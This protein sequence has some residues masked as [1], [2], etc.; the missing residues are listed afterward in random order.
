MQALLLL[1]EHGLQVHI[2]KHFCD[3]QLNDKFLQP[4]LLEYL[5]EILEFLGFENQLLEK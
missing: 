3:Q 2:K 1:H 5:Q 4:N